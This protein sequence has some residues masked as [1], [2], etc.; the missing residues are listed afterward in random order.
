VWPPSS[1]LSFVRI[2][3]AGSQQHEHIDDND[4]EL[5]VTLSRR[6]EYYLRYPTS[7]QQHRRAITFGAERTCR[8]HLKDPKDNT[9]LHFVCAATAWIPGRFPSSRARCKGTRRA[10]RQAF[11][12]RYGTEVISAQSRQAQGY[13]HPIVSVRGQWFVVMELDGQGQSNAHA[14]V[15]V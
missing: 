5:H 15:P 11:L 8:Y 3:D 10:S 9:M 14:R 4:P 1:R 2:D 12:P 13:S 6:L 7:S